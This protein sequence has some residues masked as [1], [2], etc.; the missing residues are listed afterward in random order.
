MS[1][2]PSSRPRTDPTRR[3]HL[4][5]R[6]VNIERRLSDT[7]GLIARAQEDLRITDEQVAFQ[8]DVAAEAETRMVVSETPLAD[9]EYRTAR[10]DLVRLERQRARLA[11]E[12]AELRAEQDQLLDRMLASGDDRAASG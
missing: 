1:A 7:R 6:P 11:A 5:S 2:V 8:R 3:A 9:R 12:L 4:Y 10:D